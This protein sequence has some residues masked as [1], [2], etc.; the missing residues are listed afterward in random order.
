M[1]LYDVDEAINLFAE[2]RDIDL[3]IVVQKDQSWMDRFLKTSRTKK[4]SFQSKLPVLVIH[5]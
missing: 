2:D 1:R 4:M 5:E 3:V